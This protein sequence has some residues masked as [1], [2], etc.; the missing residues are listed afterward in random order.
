M[1]YMGCYD[2]GRS[3]TGNFSDIQ[4]PLIV[5]GSEWRSRS[6]HAGGKLR[7]NVDYRKK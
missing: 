4:I 6:R 2:L 1:S 7:N 3:E 5:V